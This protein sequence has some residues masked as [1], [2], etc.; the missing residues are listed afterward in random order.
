LDAVF[1]R[2]EQ[3]LHWVAAL[4]LAI[5]SIWAVSIEMP[6]VLPEHGLW[7][8]GAFVASG[9][10]A[11]AGLDPYGIYP[12]LTPHVV[13]P[14]FES[15]NPNLNPP[16]SA[17]IFQLFDLAD[18]AVSF[19]IWRVISV[20]C[21]LAAV[22]LLLQRYVRGPQA[23]L[24][25][26]WAIGLAGFW[27][28]LYLGQIYTPLVLFA[29]IAWLQLERGNAVLAGLMIGLLVSMKPNFLVW[30]VLLFLGGYQKASLVTVATGAVI[31]LIPLL[32]FGPQIYV[33]W[34]LLVASDGDRAVF[35]TNAS[36]SGLAARLGVPLIGKIAGGLLLLGLAAWAL[37]RKPPVVAVSSFSL[38]AALLASPLG[39]IQYTLF[40]L[41][42]LLHHHQTLW[43]FVAALLLTIPVPFVLSQ[44][45]AS[46]LLQLTIGSVY[47]WALLLMLVGLVVT[48]GR[49]AAA[50]S[51]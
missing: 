41:P 21:Y 46:A 2:H 7:D 37:R 1:K 34:L 9:R 43:A 13:F 8:F 15:W 44:F 45:G 27:D 42:V 48:Y 32:V 23:L 24:Y 38:L 28:T 51:R 4:P 47:G 17:L 3:S 14:G 26:I 31:A 49:D 33:D 10:A 6:R 16:I 30:P 40:L 25:G 36:F 22:L 5:F 35:L 20:A 12:P 11:A 18:P 29:V 19:Q 50:G 39:W